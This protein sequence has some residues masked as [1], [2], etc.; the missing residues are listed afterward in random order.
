M[1][2]KE[3]LIRTIHN[4]PDD[5]NCDL[6]FIKLIKNSDFELFI[7]TFVK[8]S[9]NKQNKHEYLKFQYD[10]AYNFLY[11]YS[12]EYFIHKFCLYKEN[13]IRNLLNNLYFDKINSDILE[14]INFLCTFKISNC[15]HI[16][17]IIFNS[18]T[19]KTFTRTNICKLYNILFDL[20]IIRDYIITLDKW[21]FEDIKKNDFSILGEILSLPIS[22]KNTYF[23]IQNISKPFFKLFNNNN[24]TI[25]IWTWMN[26]ILEN[27]SDRNKESY[28]LFIQYNRN[29]NSNYFLYNLYYIIYELFKKLQIKDGYPHISLYKDVIINFKF[30]NDN[31]LNTVN[32]ILK[33]F[34]I[35]IIPT[36]KQMKYVI[37]QL[38]HANNPLNE[39]SNNHEQI[40][41]LKEWASSHQHRLNRLLNN[42]TL[43]S[44]HVVCRFIIN[45]IYYSNNIDKYLHN[46]DLSIIDSIYEF[47]SYLSHNK[48]RYISYLK[49]PVEFYCVCIKL[50]KSN[51]INNNTKTRIIEL[52]SFQFNSIYC[53]YLDFPYIQNNLFDTFIDSFIN[54]KYWTGITDDSKRN[55]RFT[56]IYLFGLISSDFQ[57]N[58]KLTLYFKNND[59]KHNLF[60][61]ILLYDISIVIDDIKKRHSYKTSN[62]VVILK[63]IKYLLSA[64][65]CE[66]FINKLMSE[67]I[68]S[69]FINVVYH[70]ILL[71]TND[72][73]SILKKD[74]I[75]I[76]NK[77]SNHDNFRILIENFITN[78][79]STRIN[80]LKFVSFN[81]VLFDK[82]SSYTII[83]LDNV[84]NDFLDP[85]TNTLIK[86]PVV[87]PASQIIM[88]KNVIIRYLTL[89]EEDPFNRAELKIDSLI[90]YN[91]TLEAK[92]IISNFKK[93]YNQ[94]KNNLK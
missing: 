52:I 13:N 31:I 41:K 90:Q 24:S 82:I 70:S 34:Q 11:T 56:I 89:T 49:F 28:S 65:H 62:F 15:K 17:K 66:I 14:F 91:H 38:E 72:K 93:K 29:T 26:E 50:I 88:D 58:C 83:N 6:F 67:T 59:L 48:L 7:F 36:I 32:L 2:L 20:A 53:K 40:I 8:I 43:N 63:Y 12:L 44:I 75:S 19:T 71:N 18:L 64:I 47:Y 42:Y 30:Q 46:I 85:I 21:L 94:W 45:T 16:L 4:I 60:W 76:I 25:Q 79:N 77:M 80:L 9:I 51:N 55:I 81:K 54:C 84:P 3:L 35:I 10:Y 68:G 1:D 61:N 37:K 86:N 73:A 33:A 69:L 74:L 39:N 78:D 27:N 87:L 92:Q 22:E 5:S 57:Q 23:A